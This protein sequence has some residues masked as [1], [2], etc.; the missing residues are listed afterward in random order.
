MAKCLSTFYL[1]IATCRGYLST[2][3]PGYHIAINFT[4]CT[5]S[6]SRPSFSSSAFFAIPS[7]S[8]ILRLVNTMDSRKTAS[9]RLNVDPNRHPGHVAENLKVACGSG[10]NRSTSLL[11]SFQTLAL[12]DVA[13]QSQMGMVLSSLDAR[14]VPLRSK[15]LTAESATQV[16]K[17]ARPQRVESRSNRCLFLLVQAESRA[18]PFIVVPSSSPDKDPLHQACSCA[19]FETG[20]QAL[21]LGKRKSKKPMDVYAVPPCLLLQLS[22][23]LASVRYLPC[24][25][26]AV[27][28]FQA[29]YE[30]LN[31]YSSVL[32]FSMEARYL[33]P[34]MVP[35]S[36]THVSSVMWWRMKNPTSILLA[37]S[38]QLPLPPP[39]TIE[40]ILPCCLRL[41]A[42]LTDTSSISTVEIP[43]QSTP[44]HLLSLHHGHNAS[45]M[46]VPQTPLFPAIED[47]SS[48]I[49][50]RTLDQNGPLHDA[51][52]LDTN[53]LSGP[54]SAGSN[55]HSHGSSN[56]TSISSVARHAPNGPAR[57]LDAAREVLIAENNIFPWVSHSWKRH[58]TF[59]T[60]G[61]ESPHP[62]ADGGFS[63]CRMADSSTYHLRMRVLYI[64]SSLTAN[65]AVA[66]CQHCV[67]RFQVQE[68]SLCC[69]WPGFAES[70][71]L[72]ALWVGKEFSHHAFF[73]VGIRPP[74]M[75]CTRMESRTL[76]SPLT[77]SSAVWTC[78]SRD[79]VTGDKAGAS[80]WSEL[81]WLAACLGA[82]PA[83]GGQQQ[84]RGK[85][86]Q[87]NPDMDFWNFLSLQSPRRL[88]ICCGSGFLCSW[89][90]PLL[91]GYC[92]VPSRA[93]P[94]QRDLSERSYDDVP[95]CGGNGQ[96]RGNEPSR[97]RGCGSR[98]VEEGPRGWSLELAN[99]KLV[100]LQDHK[101]VHELMEAQHDTNPHERMLFVSNQVESSHEP[102]AIAWDLPAGSVASLAGI[103]IWTT[104]TAKMAALDRQ[105]LD[106]H[107]VRD[108]E[109]A[110]K[111]I[112]FGWAW[113]SYVQLLGGCRSR[114][115]T[116]LVSS[117]V[118]LSDCREH[119]GINSYVIARSK[120][121]A[122]VW[123]LGFNE[124]E[125]AP[126]V[127]GSITMA[128]R[129]KL[130]ESCSQEAHGFLSLLTNILD[131]ASNGGSI[132]VGW[133]AFLV[134]WRQLGVPGNCDLVVTTR[135]RLSGT[136]A[137]GLGCVLVT[138]SLW[139]KGPC[140]RAPYNRVLL[141]CC[142]RNLN[143][144][145][146]ARE[147]R[148]SVSVHP[149]DTLTT[150]YLTV[151]WAG[152]SLQTPSCGAAPQG[153][154]HLDHQ[155]S[156]ASD[157]FSLFF[158]WH[159]RR[160]WPQLMLLLLLLSP[161]FL[162][163]QARH[164]EPQGAFPRGSWQVLLA[165]T[166][167]EQE[168]YRYRFRKRRL[169]RHCE[170]THAGSDSLSRP[171]VSGFLLPPQPLKL[172]F[173][174]T[175]HRLSTS[176][177]SLTK[178]FVCLKLLPES[179]SAHCT[180]SKQGLRIGPNLLQ[181]PC[182][183]VFLRHRM[184]SLPS[185]NVHHPPH[186]RTPHT[187]AVTLFRPGIQSAARSTTYLAI[188]SQVYQQVL[189]HCS[190]VTR[191]TLSLRWPGLPY[192][193]KHHIEK[194]RVVAARIGR[195]I[196]PI[197]LPASVERIRP[198][199]ALLTGNHELPSSP[200]KSH[201]GSL[202]LA[203]HRS[204]TMAGPPPTP[205]RPLRWVAHL[206]YTSDPI[207][208]SDHVSLE[209]WIAYCVRVCVCVSGST[210]LQYTAVER[211]AP[212]HGLTELVVGLR[213]VRVPMSAPCHAS[214]DWPARASSE[215]LSRAVMHYISSPH[216]F[217][218]S[219]MASRPP[220]HGIPT[221]PPPTYLASIGKGTGAW[222]EDVAHGMAHSTD[223]KRIPDETLPN[224]PL[225]KEK[226]YDK[227]EAR[228]YD[229]VPGIA[230]QQASGQRLLSPAW[231]GTAKSHD[232][233]NRA[234]Y[235]YRHTVDRWWVLKHS[236]GQSCATERPAYCKREGMLSRGRC[237]SYF[238]SSHPFLVA[239]TC[240]TDMNL[241][242]AI[243][244]ALTI[245]WIV[246]R[247]HPSTM[248]M[249]SCNGRLQPQGKS[250]GLRPLGVPNSRIM[251]GLF[252]FLP[253]NSGPNSHRSDNFAVDNI[254]QLSSGS[255]Q[256]NSGSKV[257]KFRVLDCFNTPRARMLPIMAS[258]KF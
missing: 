231:P 147:S 189:A 199:G 69:G 45:I 174:S 106:L 19:H 86:S 50:Y 64:S 16:D 118:C 145:I 136:P 11:K 202:R 233:S 126:K 103:E 56:L 132:F 88:F 24:Y 165:T 5:D 228:R 36:S 23:G 254:M 120:L 142:I 226:I 234:T 222:V 207:P 94:R 193:M 34:N 181:Q 104:T 208:S 55:R 92:L 39:S 197:L 201:S 247:P 119:I 59:D 61:L 70:P 235:F 114:A 214:V 204:A 185:S 113:L 219:R 236:K 37:Y 130:V 10:E 65:L 209:I 246:T 62:T 109:G 241:V 97:S 167:A 187:P 230:T 40:S 248:D 144:H 89:I 14:R 257:G 111:A 20:R 105:G 29:S 101:V 150:P 7:F 152:W 93:Q 84:R 35:T 68:S 191:R 160:I 129:S 179:P 87:G 82:C 250:L 25:F 216:P 95:M 121:P 149:H 79:A 83:A 135:G 99:V 206:P 3:L 173:E 12:R 131:P 240:R 218:G 42:Y 159:S 227:S 221:I 77:V 75:F 253:T 6:G 43:K 48:H 85:E 256:Q 154:V 183:A 51:R 98:L 81:P 47:C 220:G 26:P 177:A 1:I 74:H 41:L 2:T 80:Q 107:A 46:Y 211:R 54:D 195:P 53:L 117:N 224:Y 146:T 184:R 155:R 112:D 13:L 166:A 203:D 110:I 251:P 168:L 27:Q 245:G 217:R 213:R 255:K 49:C 237:Y 232:R 134:T 52:Q 32:F 188:A 200:S 148:V 192:G 180:V 239:T 18:L 215:F 17:S 28:V 124:V 258:C 128:V 212:G 8:S 100:F 225:E 21:K 15:T 38:H 57:L 4:S 116:D 138:P 71:V 252:D 157:H 123:G 60:A 172:Y 238:L 90:L 153:S 194:L 58:V 178:G 122:L 175:Q 91:L 137:R 249:P 133:P 31:T 143:N 22:T 108:P 140:P 44:F 76:W 30:H 9:S 141:P 205:T 182:A 73:Y 186:V 162:A 78:K 139:L 63:T 171:K 210:Q 164:D 198:Y 170:P 158:A 72:T 115:N 196:W 96:V 102:V 151:Q 242:K 125:R 243:F 67:Q 66:S 190:R 33:P 156:A 161:A 127:C 163:R 244:A 229:R 176:S 223:G 169:P